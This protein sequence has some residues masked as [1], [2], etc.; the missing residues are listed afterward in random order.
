MNRFTTVEGVPVSE[1]LK[2][3]ARASELRD[4]L[5]DGDEVDPVLTGAT[6]A[7]LFFEP[8]TRTRLSFDLAERRLGAY[9]LTYDEMTSS[10]AKG[11]SLRDTALTV[12]SI[13]ADVLV[14]RH[15]EVGMPD[16]VADW[17]GRFVVNAGDGTGQHPTQ[18][19]LDVVTIQRHFGH[20]DGLHMALIG[21]IAHSRVANGLMHALPELGVKLSLVGPSGWMPADTSL[22]TFDTLDEVIT[23]VDIAY[24]LRVQ[25]E[26]GGV[27]TEE[28]VADFRLD[29]RRA[30]RMA[31]HAVVMHPG[32][33]NR[34]VEISEGVADGARS[35]ILEQVANGV[36]SRMAVLELTRGP[37]Q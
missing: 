37:G 10:A 24:L 12:S 4:V 15:K 20:L 13:G 19:L 22:S 8:S 17:T 31:P 32:P 18:T 25:T 21:D 16:R 7:N 14:V 29:D 9:V 23:D 2:L 33:I 3:V 11:E 5:E 35:L 26:R 6:V 36:P 30:S 27:I 28:F 34:G 1:L